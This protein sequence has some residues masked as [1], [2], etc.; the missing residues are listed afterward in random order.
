MIKQNWKPKLWPYQGYIS[1]KIR[2]EKES[3]ETP[4]KNQEQGR[5]QRGNKKQGQ[6]QGGC[7]FTL[8]FLAITKVNPWNLDAFLWGLMLVLHAII[9]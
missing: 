7:L 5:N 9:S 1:A 3:H 6:E 8:C 2:E 4:F